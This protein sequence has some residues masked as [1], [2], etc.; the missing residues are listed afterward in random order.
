MIIKHLDSPVVTSRKGLPQGNV[1]YIEPYRKGIGIA[2]FFTNPTHGADL[3]KSAS[4]IGTPLG[5]HNGTDSVFWTGSNLVGDNFTFNSTTQAYSGTRSISGV[6]TNDGDE[7]LLKSSSVISTG[8]YIAL[9]GTIYATRWGV[10]DNVTLRLRLAGTDIGTLSI[11]LTSYINIGQ[12]NSWQL[13]SI[14]MTALSSVAAD[15]DEVVIHTVNAT[16]TSPRYYLDVLQ[17]EESSGSISYTVSAPANSIYHITGFGITIVDTIPSTLANATVPAFTWNKLLSLNQLP[18]GLVS[19]STINGV[20]T[21]TGVF[22]NHID[23]ATYPTTTIQ[24]GGDA[25]TQYVKYDVS[26]DVFGGS[27]LVLDSRTGDTLQFTVNDDLSHFNY[28]R[29][30]TNGIKEEIIANENDF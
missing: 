9:T 15:F 14:P 3:N 12:L 7:A 4:F 2:Q 5:V 22:R 18:I 30:L 26:F 8:S 11:S 24:S 27:P 1:T 16:G 23:F 28:F 21:F 10:D 20:T 25:T 17:F 29:I 13:F 19:S 6:N